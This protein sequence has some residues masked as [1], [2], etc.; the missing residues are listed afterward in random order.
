MKL[1]KTSVTLNGN[2]AGLT[3]V[4]GGKLWHVYDNTIKQSRYFWTKRE[5]EKKV[6]ELYAGDAELRKA[7]LNQLTQSR[8]RAV[9]LLY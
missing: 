5:A 4:F 9:N 2:Y 8:G 1:R 3:D 6:R 7:I